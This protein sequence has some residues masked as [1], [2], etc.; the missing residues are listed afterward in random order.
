MICHKS[1]S[2]SIDLCVKS[3]NDNKVVIIPTD[4]VYGFSA[5]VL[6]ESYENLNSKKIKKIKG[7][8][9]GKSFIQLISSPEEIEK[10][11]DAKIPSDLLKYWPGPLTIICEDKRYSTSNCVITTAFRCPGDKWLRDIIFQL[12]APIYSTSVNRSG[13][14]ILEKE[15][16]IIREFEN[17]VDLIVLNGDTKDQLPSTIVKINN[18]YTYEVIRQGAIKL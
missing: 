8:E 3:L 11:S 18:D 10:Y 13:K 7:R 1:D 4:T 15:N 14:P 6:N 17:E 16:E 12:K 9:E 2:N 5:L